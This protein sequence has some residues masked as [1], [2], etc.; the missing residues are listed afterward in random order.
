MLTMITKLISFIRL[1]SYLLFLFISLPTAAKPVKPQSSLNVL[2]I[3]S[4]FEGYPWAAS[5]NR[6]IREGFSKATEPI[7][8]WTEYLDTKRNQDPHYFKKLREL[9][10]TKYL[11]KDLDL[12]ITVDNEAYDFVMADRDTLFA[13]IPLVFTGFNGYEPALLEHRPLVTGVIEEN[14]F[15]ETINVALQLHPDTKKVAFV[16]PNAWPARVAWVK[17]IPEIYAGRIEFINVTANTLNGIDSELE[18]LGSNTVVIP[19]NSFQL[20][21]GEYLPFEDLISHL[22]TKAYPV[23]GLWDIALGHGIVGGKLVSGELQGSNASSLA[24]QILDG[25]RVS[26]VPVMDS[27]PNSYMFDWTKMQQFKIKISDLPEGAIVLNRPRSF[28]ENNKLLIWAV[29]F[30][31]VFLTVLIIALS[32]NILRR[33]RVEQKLS[34][35]ASHDALTGLVNRREFEYR[36]KR[37]LS[38]NK[39]DIGENVLCYMDL[40]Q[41]KVI[42]DNYGHNAG[43]ELLRQLSTVLEE[44]VRH[45]DTLARLGG[46][47]FGLLM[48]HCSLDDAHRVAASIQE[49]IQNYQF[50][51]DG[52]SCKVGVSIGLVAVTKTTTK[53]TELLLDADAACYIAKN[54]GPNHIHTYHEEDTE[55]AQRHGEMQWVPRIQHALEKNQFCLYAQSIVSLENNTDKHYELLIRL[56]DDK[57]EIIPPCTFLPVAERYNLMTQIDCWVIEKA[58]RFLTENPEFQGQTSFISINLSGQS[59]ADQDMLDFIIKELEKADIENKKICF[60]IT[61]TAAISNIMTAKNFIS[62]LKDLGCRFALDDFGSGLSSFAYLKN[63]PVD[64]LKIDGMFVKDIVEDLID[65]AMVKSINEIGQVMG[66]QTIAEF[67]ENDEI[68]GMLREIGVNYAQGYGIHKP[69]PFKELLSG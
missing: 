9:F 8:F 31:M 56:I 32:L 35:Q 25:A 14:S 57:G 45:R 62:T 1:P 23:Y 5:M 61:E 41:F 4:S 66:M 42:N 19:L 12:I 68:K 29:I 21:S 50:V 2:V 27:S 36:A 17:R 48:E 65:H 6:G 28:Y 3:H 55:I 63:L 30:I 43:D 33:K 16:L 11:G 37:L 52:H 53:L 51:W 44:K 26:D 49:A 47:E 24:L 7:E 59:L 60:E 15:E 69:Q 39:Q 54:K 38:A 34:Y 18:A 58:F 67:V 10:K 20:D 40:D 22:A 64:Y 13:N 46:D